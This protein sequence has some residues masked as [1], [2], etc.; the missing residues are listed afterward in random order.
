[1]GLGKG[2][3]GVG[4]RIGLGLGDGMGLRVAWYMRLSTKHF[5]S[6]G[7]FSLFLQL[8]V[9]STGIASEFLMIFALWEDMLGVVL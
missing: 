8:Q 3:R 7:Q 6:N 2:T 9:L 4:L 1:M 5:P